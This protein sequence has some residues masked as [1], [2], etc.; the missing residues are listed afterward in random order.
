MLDAL[1]DTS[2]VDTSNTRLL[3]YLASEAEN[4]AE[5]TPDLSQRKVTIPKVVSAFGARKL[6]QGSSWW[7]SAGGREKEKGERMAAK[8]NERKNGW[9]VEN[10]FEF[11][12]KGNR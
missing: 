7:H 4:Q 3:I 2:E 12:V 9:P 5:S 1:I 10:C 6:G 8:C 11:L